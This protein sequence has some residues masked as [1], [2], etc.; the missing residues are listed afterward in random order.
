ME[1]KINHH[2]QQTNIHFLQTG[3]A[4]SHSANRVKAL[5]GK[6]ITFDGLAHP[7]LNWGLPT[8]YLA[9]DEIFTAAEGAQ[10]PFQA[11]EIATAV[12]HTKAKESHNF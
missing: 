10:L 7:K 8:L 5:K 12:A 1:V 2:Q 11:A 3:W 6:N 9:D 4:Y